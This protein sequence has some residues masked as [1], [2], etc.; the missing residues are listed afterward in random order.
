M[1]NFLNWDETWDFVKSLITANFVERNFTQ[2]LEFS[3]LICGMKLLQVMNHSQNLQKFL[4]AQK[5]VVS[6]YNNFLSMK[7][8]KLP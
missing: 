1:S 3:D 4:C 2:T 7:Y 6:W 5:F 8:F